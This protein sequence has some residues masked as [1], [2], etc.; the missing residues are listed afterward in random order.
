[1]RVRNFVCKTNGS[2]FDEFR[3]FICAHV[4]CSKFPKVTLQ[5]ISSEAFKTQFNEYFGYQFNS[6]QISD[7]VSENNYYF[8]PTNQE[9]QINKIKDEEG[10]D[11]I[12]HFV[13]EA[14]TKE[15][16]RADMDVFSFIRVK[17]AF[18]RE[19]NSSIHEYVRPQL[20]MLFDEN[21][22]NVGLL[23]GHDIA[24]DVQACCKESNIFNYID[25][26]GKSRREKQ[27]HIN[28]YTIQDEFL[29][30]IA[31][32]MCDMLVGSFDEISYEA[33]CLRKIMLLDMG[34]DVLN[35]DDTMIP[36][37]VVFNKSCWFPN[38][39]LLLEFTDV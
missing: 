16:K 13:Y 34:R 29:K 39:Q 8:D 23:Y 37:Q 35:F 4:L 10:G 17:Q 30:F 20:D 9:S 5:F 15:F 24:S 26:A 27:T 18:L 38:S 11:C 19:L 2:V 32:T 33:I 12:T 3:Q 31:L 28:T 7:V 22:I 21:K 25:F 14:V 6:T 1:M 36:K